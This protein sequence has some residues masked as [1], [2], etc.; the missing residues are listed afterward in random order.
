[1]EKGLKLYQTITSKISAER[2]PIAL[3]IP[4]SD[5]VIERWNNYFLPALDAFRKL[6]VPIDILPYAPRLDES[7]Y[8]YYPIHMNEAVLG[9][10]LRERTVL[11]LANVSGFQQTD[12]DLIKAFV[13]RGGVVVAFG[14]QIPYGR[15]YERKDLFGGDGQLDRLRSRIAFSPN[16]ANTK[17]ESFVFPST[18]LPSWTPDRASVLAA[19]GDGNAAILSNKFGKGTVYTVLPEASF[20]AD[21]F[22]RLAYQVM[23]AALRSAGGNGLVD[24]SG[25]DRNMDFASTQA[26]GDMR[27]AIVN[28]HPLARRITLS[29]I[30]DGAT[31]SIQTGFGDPIHA[32][33]RAR[34]DISVPSNE[35]ILV[36]CSAKGP[37]GA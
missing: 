1:V 14:P 21:Q 25:A 29:N 28:H 10:L 20:A 17:N 7:V 16:S 36:K 30:K 6:G 26:N 23:N 11:V 32:R 15:T 3:Y 9:R 13:E 12:S 2:N 19:Y 31:C 37:G 18:N 27:M 24:V 8:P 33:P 4:Y 5:F 34:L 35:V 22:P